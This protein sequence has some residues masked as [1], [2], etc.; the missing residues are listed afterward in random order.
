MTWESEGGNG[1]C[2]DAAVLDRVIK[3]D[4]SDRGL[5]NLQRTLVHYFNHTGIFKRHYYQIKP[6]FTS[7]FSLRQSFTAMAE[8]FKSSPEFL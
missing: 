5:Y 4:L 2:E 6:Q 1:V 7:P 8:Y 3:E